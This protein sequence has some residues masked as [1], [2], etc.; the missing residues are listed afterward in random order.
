MNKINELKEKIL[1]SIQRYYVALL[2][3]ALATIEMIMVIQRDYHHLSTRDN[4]KIVLTLI[5]GAIVALVIRNIIE[6]FSQK[7][8]SPNLLYLLIPILMVFVYL[9]VLNDMGL[10]SQILKYCILCLLSGL[11]FF[12]IPF[13]DRKEDSDY[14]SYKVIMS[15]IFTGL[16]YVI[17]TLGLIFTILSIAILFEI[18]INEHVYVQIAIFILGFIMPAIFLTDIPESALKRKEY[19]ELI[20]KL[21]MYLIFPILSLYTVVLYAYFLKILLTLKWPTNVLGNLVIYYSLISIFVLYFTNNLEKE[22]TWHNKF[23]S[24]YPYTLILPMLMMLISFIIRINQYGFTEA[25]YYALVCFLFV[26]ITIFIIKTKNKVK[27]I[28]L[29]LSILLLI[30]TFGPLSAFNISRIS[31]TKRL[32][33]ILIKNNMLKD[34][35]IIKNSNLNEITKDEIYQLLIYINER[36]GFD[37]IYFLPKGFELDDMEEVFGFSYIL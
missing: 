27:Y 35:T 12:I 26:M 20:M 11:L 16:C 6:R 34:N 4:M 30:S 31:Q 32:E 9:V 2:L 37:D 7:I 23:I 24:I 8:K 36:H 29:T 18:T 28:P 3:F 21:V 15:L 33:N 17:L 14:Y 22:N 5:Y 19:P 10:E 1:I 13:I 25:R